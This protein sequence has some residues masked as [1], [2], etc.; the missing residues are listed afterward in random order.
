[1]EIAYIPVPIAAGL[2]QKF[3]FVT[4]TQIADVTMVKITV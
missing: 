2:Y 4:V 3:I 1:M